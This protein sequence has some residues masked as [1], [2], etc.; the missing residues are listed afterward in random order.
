[1]QGGKR[2]Q[3]KRKNFKVLERSAMIELPH[4]EKG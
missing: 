2:A 3:L 4:C 1:M